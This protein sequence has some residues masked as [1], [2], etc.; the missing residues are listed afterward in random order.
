MIDSS[1]RPGAIW[2][3]FPCFTSPMTISSLA[4]SDASSES[5]ETG[6][7]SRNPLIPKLCCL[8]RS[9][10]LVFVIN[11]SATYLLW[12][13]EPA[14]DG[15]ET[16]TPLARLFFFGLMLSSFGAGCVAAF[17]F[18]RA[19]ASSHTKSACGYAIVNW[20]QAMLGSLGMS[21]P[22]YIL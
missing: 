20:I 4:S 14:F 12:P 1:R 18:R 13:A 15:Y 2:A 22:N 21:N 11:A 16:C 10:L 5:S 6:K 8:P 3:V 19:G 17:L 9:Y 7:S